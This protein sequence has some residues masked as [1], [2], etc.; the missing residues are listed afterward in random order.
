MKLEILQMLLS[1]LQQYALF[2]HSLC[3][4]RGMKES[5]ALRIRESSSSSSH[6]KEERKRQSERASE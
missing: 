5:N 1:S 2:L 6:V 4:V 3:K